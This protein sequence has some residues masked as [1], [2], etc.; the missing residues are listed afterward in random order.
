MSPT[1]LLTWNPR[2][3]SWEDTDLPDALRFTERGKRWKGSWSC[4]ITKKIRPGDRVFLM[5]LGKEPRGIVASGWVVKPEGYKPVR[6]GSAV[7]ED[8]HWDPKRRGKM[9]LYVDIDFDVALDPAEVLPWRTLR[10][11]VDSQMNWAPENSGVTVGEKVARR[12]E[13]AWSQHV[14]Q[15]RKLRKLSE[16]EGGA[17]FGNWE[18]NRRVEEKALKVVERHYKSKDWHVVD[19]SKQKRGYD[20]V[21]RRGGAEEHVEVKGVS[22]RRVQFLITRNELN[23]WKRDGEYV[24]AVVTDVFNRARIHTLRGRKGRE[25]LEMKPAVYIARLRKKR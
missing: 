4:G 22:G 21:C 20:L 3:I 2:R 17:G 9:A 14:A 7:Y 15:R 1:Y 16:A 6:K 12:L 10:S 11:D 8:S 25:R 5:K 24:V 23:T 18:E 19:V 13:K